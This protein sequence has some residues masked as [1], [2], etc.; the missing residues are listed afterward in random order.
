M[1]MQ[2]TIILTVLYLCLL[3]LTDGL[4]DLFHRSNF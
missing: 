1:L 3:M 4:I 2:Q